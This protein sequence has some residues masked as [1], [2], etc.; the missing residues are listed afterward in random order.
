MLRYVLWCIFEQSKIICKKYSSLFWYISIFIKAGY[1][2][3]FLE[4]RLQ[5]LDIAL[6]NFAMS[7]KKQHQ[8]AS[9]G[10]LI[11]LS[12]L[13]KTTTVQTKPFPSK[14][15]TSW[16]S[17]PAP[18]SDSMK[19]PLCPPWSWCNHKQ[20]NNLTRTTKRLSASMIN[21]NHNYQLLS[22]CCN[23]RL[24]MKKCRCGF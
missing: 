3:F 1:F 11:G 5:D 6:L 24:S 19:P 10:R 8:P 13:K 20:R 12:L 9:F 14:M 4:S 22:G 17:S 23:I 2:F 15:Y 18:C 7:P 21:S 16:N